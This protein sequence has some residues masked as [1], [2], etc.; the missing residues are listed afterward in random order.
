[1]VEKESLLLLW[2]PGDQL[3]IWL[4]L[5]YPNGLTDSLFQKI[6]NYLEVLILGLE[7]CT[8]NLI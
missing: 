3:D 8:K 7:A 6:N 5:L 4:W 2:G 1:M